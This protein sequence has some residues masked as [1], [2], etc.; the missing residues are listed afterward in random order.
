MNT[1]AVIQEL[2]HDIDV[3]IEQKQYKYAVALEAALK[4]FCGMIE[5]AA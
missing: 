5:V 4:E 3:A 2:L 1:D